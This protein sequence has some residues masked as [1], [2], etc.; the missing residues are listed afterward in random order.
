MK[1]IIATFLLAVSLSVM[2]GCEDPSYGRH[3]VEWPGGSC[4]GDLKRGSSGYTSWYYIV[5]QDGTKVSNLTN[6]KVV[7]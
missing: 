6:F 2:T 5:C 3:E 7:K 4:T 1:N